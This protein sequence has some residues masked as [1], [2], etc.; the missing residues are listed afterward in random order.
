[1]NSGRLAATSVAVL[2][3]ATGAAAQAQELRAAARCTGGTDEAGRGPGAAVGAGAREDPRRSEGQRRARRGLSRARRRC[4]RARAAAARGEGGPRFADAHNWLGV[5]L[6]DGADFPQGIASLR[7]AIA[8]DPKHTRAYAN[9]G[10]ALA[11]SGELDEAVEVFRKALALD[12]E[13]TGRALQP[14]HGPAREGRPRGRSAAPASRRRGRSATMR[15]RT[16]S[17]DRPC[18]RAASSAARSRRSNARSRSIPSCA[19]GTTRSVP[20]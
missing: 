1:M 14:G 20:R 4:P 19:R 16:T 11:K 5:A 18:G 12:P 10:S 3:S 2:L 17:S 9:L 13:S 7:K 6:L 15:P 8:L